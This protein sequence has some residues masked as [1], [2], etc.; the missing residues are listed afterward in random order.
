MNTFRE[1]AYLI[2]RFVGILALIAAVLYSLTTFLGP[3]YP[4]PESVTNVTMISHQLGLDLFAYA[5]DHGG[6]YPEGKSSTEI[7]QKLLDGGYI[8]SPE[9]LY[10]PLPGK[11][12]P[13]QNAKVL[14]PENVCWDVT[15][16]VTPQASDKVPIVFLTGYKIRY[17][18]NASAVGLHPADWWLPLFGESSYG[19]AVC[20]KTNAS[21]VMKIAPDSTV[22]HFIAADF[23]PRGM[24][25]H[26][27]TPEGE[28]TP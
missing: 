2:G 14:K 11:V 4:G 25:F 22:P 23:D 26:Q 15:A 28:L 12:N 27:L 1:Y 5:K 21:I 8:A 17:E 19:I 18:P 6:K 3:S 20:Y 24:T 7:F 13:G 9:I 10:A 16:G